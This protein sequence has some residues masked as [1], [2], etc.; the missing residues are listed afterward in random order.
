MPLPTDDLLSAFHDG[1]VTSA[2]RAAVEQRLA[3][4]AD[5]RRELSEI[6]EISALLKELPRDRL[7]SEF[8]QQVLQ[9]IEREML[10]P[11]QPTDSTELSSA[12]VSPTRRWIGAAAVLTSA[13]G[14]L[15]LLRTLDDPAGRDGKKAQH[16]AGS[17]SPYSAPAG[18][19]NDSPLPTAKSDSVPLVQPGDVA[20]GA[21]GQ[22]AVVAN[23]PTNTLD[24][25][26]M[27]GGFAGE[28]LFFDQAALGTAEVGDVVRAIQRTEGD[29][30][31]V[32]LLTVVDRQQGLEGLQLL[33][34]NNQFARS[35][36]VANTKSNRVSSPRSGS[37]E[38]QA[39]LVQS[40]AAQLATALKQL[41]QEK[42]LQSLEVDQPILLAQLDEARSG[43]AALTV[44]ELA[45]E[46]KRANAKSLPE[47]AS[48][49]RRMKPA[50][51]EV[52][53]KKPAAPA[54]AAKAKDARDEKEQLA[55]QT[56]FGVSA[57]VL[58]QNQ[59]SQNRARGLS[60]V[61]PRSQTV[62]EKDANNSADHRPLQVLFVL[63]DQSQA[64]KQ[65]IPPGNSS[66]PAAPAKTRSEPVKPNNQDG[67]A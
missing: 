11:S 13:A 67:A 15:L 25:A 12:R 64:G 26:R 28:N 30:V 40:D 38:M 44:K 46:A 18:A 33:L 51:P 39:V 54:A 45:D 47:S 6:R 8:P 31:A 5:A 56:R 20:A 62:T 60:K 34:S 36:E 27:A 2:E 41:R 42:Y 63:V 19:A 43:R 9:S 3:T 24:G 1:E 37:D 7:P 61:T 22:N 57:Q 21:A 49:T 58:Q 17:P 16:L 65:Q 23:S 32:V 10:I 4:S 48:S 52:G 59:L 29:E 66:K 35:E 50:L 55:N 53:D 14:L